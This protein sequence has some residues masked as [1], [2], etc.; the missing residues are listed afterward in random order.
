ML[1]VTLRSAVAEVEC[2][3]LVD[4]GADYCLFPNFLAEKL[5][6]PASEARVVSEIGGYGGSSSPEDQTLFWSVGLDVAPGCS[7]S[8]Y[9][10]FSERQDQVAFGILG[11]LGFFSE[12]GGVYFDHRAGWF[13]I[14]RPCGQL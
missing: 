1:R 3:A 4:S 8:T 9:V 10:G 13:G 7:I 6:L 12:V 2:D 5:R 14:K 11:Q